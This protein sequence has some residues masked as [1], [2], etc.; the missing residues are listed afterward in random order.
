MK[1]D[2]E[3]IE[4]TLAFL[5]TDFNFEFEYRTTNGNEEFYSYK[6]RYGSINTEACLYMKKYNPKYAIRISEKNF[7]FENN[8]KSVPLYATFCI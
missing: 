8:I 2:K 1:T 5:V 7:G 3:I 6:N 4:K